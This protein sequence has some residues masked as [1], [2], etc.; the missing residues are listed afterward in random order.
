MGT[1]ATPVP[2]LA[3]AAVT[4]SDPVTALAIASLNFGTAACNLLMTPQG[5]ELLKFELK[6]AETF[7]AAVESAVGKLSNAIRSG[8]A[9]L[10]HPVAK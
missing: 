5:Q 1:S 3:T 6:T 4:I 10:F 9:K 7:E 2:A 8:V